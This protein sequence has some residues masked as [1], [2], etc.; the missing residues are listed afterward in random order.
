MRITVRMQAFEQRLLSHALTPAVVAEQVLTSRPHWGC[1]VTPESCKG[2]EVALS[3]FETK[4]VEKLAS[5]YTEAHSPPADIRDKLDLGF[6]VSGQSLE[7]FEI[8]SK[9]RDPSVKI[10]HPIAKVTYV[11]KSKSCKVY[12]MRADLKWHRYDPVPE[13]ASL[14]VFFRLVEDDQYGC[15]KG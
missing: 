12:W 5:D 14:E 6:R 11:K 9:F 7:L 4:R 10:E 8:R 13:I 2:Y 15:F 3:E 1:Q